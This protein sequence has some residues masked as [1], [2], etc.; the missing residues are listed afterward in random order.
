[1]HSDH[2][3]AVDLLAAL[4]LLDLLPEGLPFRALGVE[5]AARLVEFA[6]DRVLVQAQDAGIGSHEPLGE[7]F[8]RE[9]RVVV[10]L[11]RLQVLRQD[12]GPGRR[13]FQRQPLASPARWTYSANASSLHPLPG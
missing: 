8:V 13:L 2:E 6:D 12:A 5:L 1:D 4:L 7:D 10:F 3:V 9:A 11:D